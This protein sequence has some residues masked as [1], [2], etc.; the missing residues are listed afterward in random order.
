MVRQIRSNDGGSLRDQVF[1]VLNRN[2][3]PVE[4]APKVLSQC[5]AH[6]R[7][8]MTVESIAKECGLKLSRFLI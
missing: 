3:V 2:E 7:N 5:E 8:R 4:K 1:A 6:I